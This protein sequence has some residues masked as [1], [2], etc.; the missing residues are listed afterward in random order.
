[1]FCV[2]SR[3]VDK[4]MAVEGRADNYLI[5]PSK[6]EQL[7]KTV[8]KILE[9]GMDNMVKDLQVDDKEIFVYQEN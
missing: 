2:L 3:D 4:G 9:D 5:K 8:N 7:L 1:M 6:T